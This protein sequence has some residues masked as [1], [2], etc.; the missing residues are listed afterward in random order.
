LKFWR[1]FILI[2]LA[3]RCFDF[4]KFWY[5]CWNRNFDFDLLLLAKSKFWNFDFD[6]LLLAKSK[7]WNF[8]FD[9]LLLTRSKF[10]QNLIIVSSKFQ[11]RNRPLDFGFDFDLEFFILISI[12]EL[13]FLLWHRNYDFSPGSRISKHFSLKRTLTRDFWPLV[14]FIKQLPLRPWDTG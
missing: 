11:C 10:Q 1:N 7:F 2:L 9:L 14:F 6:L 4:P 5:W 12:Q 13:E 8:D 3:F